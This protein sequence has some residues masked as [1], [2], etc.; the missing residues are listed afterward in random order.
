MTIEKL[1]QTYWLPDR[2]GSVGTYSENLVSEIMRIHITSNHKL[3]STSVLTLERLQYFERYLWPQCRLVKE[4]S[5]SHTMSILL[6]LNEKYQQGT[7]QSAWNLVGNDDSAFTR[8]FDS[9][10]TMAMDRVLLPA[11]KTRKERVGGLDPITAL[12]IIVQFL[13][14]C[15]DSL[16][17]TLV[18]KCVMPLVGLSLWHH[19]RETAGPLI[20]REFDR[21][22]QLR[23]LWKHAIKQCSLTNKKLNA[24][25]VARNQRNRDFIPLLVT[26][27]IQKQLSLEN[28][29]DLVYCVQFIA[30]LV[31]LE[32][33]LPTRRY[34]NQLLRDFQIIQLCQQSP[35]SQNQRFGEQLERLCHVVYFPVND[36]TGHALAESE[37]V[38]MQYR[39]VVELQQLAFERYPQELESLAL[40]GVAQLVNDGAK[41]LLERL[42][43]LEDKILFGLAVG[44]GIRTKSLLD[45]SAENSRGFVL[46]AFVERYQRRQTIGD[47]VSEISIYP[48]EKLLFASDV[49]D[50]TDNY[51]GHTAFIENTVA[52]TTGG[53]RYPTLPVSRINMQFLTLHDYL[54]RSFELYRLES[55]YGIREDIDDA[56]NRLQPKIT[57]E[58]EQET[59]VGNTHFE[60]WAKMA[61]PL[62]S[63]NVVDVKRPQIG[64]KTPSMVRADITLDLSD[65]IDTVR[66]EWDAEMR[67]RDIL[68]LL[69]VV[70]SGSTSKESRVR[71]CVQYVRGCEIECRLDSSTGKPIENAAEKDKNDCIRMFRVLLD[72]HQYRMDTA[73]RPGGKQG[74]HGA[75]NVVVRRRPQQN[76][77]K[78]VLDTIRGMMTSSL[79]LPEWLST[80]F[81]GYGD[82]HTAVSSALLCLLNPTE[83]SEETVSIDFGDTFV[84]ESHLRASFAANQQ[85]ELLDDEFSP[86]SSCTI[87]WMSNKK[88]LTVRTAV[89]KVG[90]L[91]NELLKRKRNSVEFTPAQ[92]SA[93]GSASSEGLSLIVGPPG[94][95]KTDVAVQIVS[96]LYHAHPGQK[97]LLITHSNM[98]LN[99]LFG[100]IVDRDIEP[101]HLL[102]L[103]H[104]EEDLDSTERYSKAG[105]VDSYLERRQQLLDEVQ[106]LAESMQ[107]RGDFGSSCENA[108]LF[109]ITQV[110]VRWES[111]QR[112][113]TMG[114]EGVEFPFAQYFAQKQQSISANNSSIEEMAGCFDYLRGMF[115]ELQD[116][117]PFELLRS[118]QERSN[119]LLTNQARIVAMTCTHAALKRQELLVLG[120]A[121]DSVVMEEAGQ[122]LDIESFI[123][124][125]LQ[126][127]RQQG[128][129]KR[130]VMIG[131]HNQLP[132]VVKN[133]GLRAYANMEQSLF[134]RLVRLGVPYVELNRQAR[135]RPEIADLYRY[136]YQDLGD[137]KSL[138]EQGPFAQP[139]NVGFKHTYQFIDVADFNG[140]GESEPSRYFYQN[141]GE[142]EYMVAVFQYMR[143]LGYPA[144]SIALLTTYNGQRALVND[145]LERRCGW[146]EFFGRPKTVSTVDQYQ[147]QQSDYVLLS[148]V[149]TRGHVGHI[150]DVRR[151]TVALSRARL[152]LYVFGR[153]AL[154]ENCYELSQ[155]MDKLKGNMLELCLDE[156][157]ANF[158]DMGNSSSRAS[159]FIDGVEMMG[160]LVCSMVGK[161]GL[162]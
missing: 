111:Y 55:A 47:R 99:Q 141:L 94:T 150:R 137:L 104:G 37:Y 52:S 12:S 123:P 107:I 33:Q 45:P 127:G 156:H 135:A 5:D 70:A 117:Q 147:G 151:L 78:A 24:E 142:A 29:W 145:V 77:F 71:E 128:G 159:T 81:L 26:D 131:D 69:S 50:Q 44:V 20:E 46:Q 115:D 154:F 38:E 91:S 35:I 19:I 23:R 140:Q 118:N 102:R 80:A 143:L 75:L 15:F 97:I 67:P 160:K 85:I 14:A 49:L 129:L 73:S 162:V 2:D 119:Y 138:V 136:R 126:Q 130:L 93:I 157:N 103:G 125:A 13:N 86:A 48:T 34:L 18:R 11:E 21:V 132:P 62:R 59:S 54:E 95:G 56:V 72:T 112:Q 64:E 139:F 6:M 96:N 124:L 89:D 79:V 57:Y 7:I 25:E 153:R 9:I 108:H 8:L 158:S 3:T 148:L 84:S 36:L 133:S 98:A 51:Q 58:T 63:V 4:M 161:K 105:R 27:F 122:I 22:P 92:V 82:P 1:A 146:S 113:V 134:S 68:M 101:R 106:A 40:S 39:D 144:S 76:N 121:Y 114:K 109:Y 30:F 41:G 116:I 83:H 66:K 61:I 90:V 32:L 155:S 53:I 110:K 17:T 74:V 149:R 88:S 31:S 87:D 16:E 65:Y 120:F 43:A 28:S 42:D 152:G 10:L 60:G 100:K